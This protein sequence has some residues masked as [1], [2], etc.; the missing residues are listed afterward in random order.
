MLEKVTGMIGYAMDKVLFP[1]LVF[2]P[3]IS[4][5]ISSIMVTGILFV[6]YHYLYKKNNLPQIKQQLE[7][8]KQEM[9]K[10]QSRESQKAK[11]L[12]SKYLQLNNKF[13]KF[14]T[15]VLIA[16]M[17][18]GLLF[19]SWMDFRFQKTAHV[20]LPF[21][22]PLIGKTLNWIGWYLLLSF[23]IAWIIRKVVGWE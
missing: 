1:L 9:L 13:V 19:F 4:L 16:S 5:T 23:T 21:N 14:T 8:L 3:Y 6:V 20:V 18:I 22:L 7:F 17:I 2:K 12:L 15:E 10:I 11:E